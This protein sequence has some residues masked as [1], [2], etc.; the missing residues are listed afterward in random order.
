MKLST[1]LK[2]NI[3]LILFYII[4]MIFISSVIYFDKNIKVNDENI[5]YIN[6]ASFIFFIIYFTFE[7]LR[8]KRYYSEMN[9]ILIN[10]QDDIILSMPEAITYE[11]NLYHNLLLK[12]HEEYNLK[13]DR[14]YKENKENIDFVNY[15][16]HEI[17]TPIAASKLLI[18]HSENKSKEDLLEKLENEL[19]LIEN[20]VNQS[21]YYSRTG[22]FS[23]DY[24]IDD[25]EIDKLVKSII[26]KH[27]R[28]FIGKKIKIDLCNLDFIVNSD[29]K[30]LSFIIE[31][32]ILNSLK[33][34]KE[35]GTIK[36]SGIVSER[37][38]TITIEDNGIGIKEEDIHRVFDKG[39]T[40]FNGRENSKSTGIGLYLCRT[41]SQKLGHSISIESKHLEF[42]KVT[43]HFPKLIDYYSVM[44]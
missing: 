40:G 28:I 39:F 19:C 5:I 42:T 31:Q 38:K 43:I 26:K 15:W 37:E 14:F 9:S 1:Y 2:D 10:S 20:F 30:W 13:I 4:T 35:H 23:K 21:L 17:K 36:I 41:L 24:F 29:K 3:P 27:A 18:E 12:L 16:V 44:K 6:I 11:Q 25:I 7:Y 34:T 22:S 33:Y 32:I 8:K